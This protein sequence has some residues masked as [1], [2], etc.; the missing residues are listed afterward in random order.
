MPSTV[1]SKP[2]GI[3]VVRCSRPSL[4]KCLAV[5]GSQRLG[6]VKSSPK[7]RARIGSDS[8]EDDK[9][10]RR[11]RVEPMQLEDNAEKDNEEM[12]RMY[13]SEVNDIFLSE[14]H[15]DYCWHCPIELA[16]LFSFRHQ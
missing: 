1:K 15:S 10:M 2:L 8:D 16:Q 4:R 6:E 11:S 7:K 13:D 5:S 12:R 3:C 9:A 14:D